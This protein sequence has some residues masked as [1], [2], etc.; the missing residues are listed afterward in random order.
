[1]GHYNP[2]SQDYDL[3]PSMLCVLILWRHV[4]FKDDSERKI[5]RTVFVAI[6][7][8][9]CQKSANSQISGEHR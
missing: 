3:T 5:F 8:I 6:L 4:Q 1:M 7:F 9:F 2:L